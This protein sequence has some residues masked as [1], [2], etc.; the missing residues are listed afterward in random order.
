[1]KVK[2]TMILVGAA[3]H[4]M[5]DNI[6]A[7]PTLLAKLDAAE[8]GAID[9][10]GILIM[11][12]GM[13]FLA[14]GFIIYPIVMNATDD[15]LAYAGTGYCVSNAVS[16]NS[17]YF[18][19]FNAIVGIT[20]LLILIGFLSAAVFAMYLGVKVMKGGEGGT[21]LDLGTMLL[22]GISLIFIAIGLIILPVTLDGICTVF[23]NAGS[24]LSTSYVGLGPILRVTPL[25]VLISFVAGAVISGF[26][27]IKRLGG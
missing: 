19:G 20:P 5:V 22:L 2:H 27:G 3:F 6:K 11:G 25:L 18:T 26:F 7:A 15:L 14:V 8:R 10:G 17:T 24:Y 12:I 4:Q 23:H 21:K 9:I 16:C 13:V 1:M